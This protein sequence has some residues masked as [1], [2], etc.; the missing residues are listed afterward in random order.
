L[1]AEAEHW[2]DRLAVAH[3]RREGVKA[4]L[5]IAAAAFSLPLIRSIPAAAAPGED[6][7]QPC[8]EESRKLRVAAL[9]QCARH[10]RAGPVGLLIALATHRLRDVP[11]LCLPEAIAD[12]WDRERVCQHVDC[13]G[14]GCGPLGC[15]FPPGPSKGGDLPPPPPPP[16]DC[17]DGWGICPAPPGGRVSCL[18]PGY[19]CC[20]SGGQCPPGYSCCSQGT[21]YFCASR[22]PG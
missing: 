14:F 10:G 3:T 2:L 19:T 8:I 6:C 9:K 11:P 18:P 5:A 4:T 20:G 12:A 13:G 1:S 15:E 17:P 22:C 7:Y 21:A 16:N